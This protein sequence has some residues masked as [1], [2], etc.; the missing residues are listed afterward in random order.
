MN[1]SLEAFLRGY[2]LFDV[3]GKKFMLYNTALAYRKSVKQE[4]DVEFIG[5][6]IFKKWQCFYMRFNTV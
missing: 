5:W 4:C 1:K 2:F 3:N 6:H